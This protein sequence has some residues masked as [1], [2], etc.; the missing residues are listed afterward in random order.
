YN[1]GVGYIGSGKLLEATFEY[2]KAVE[3]SEG[4]PET[5][6]AL[7]HAYAVI[8]KNAQAEKILGDLE[9][10]AKSVYVSPYTLATIYASLDEKDRA[11]D[12]LEEA[13]NEK[14]LDISWH[15]KADLRVDNLRSDPRFHD[16]MRR[17]GL[18]E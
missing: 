18:K 10:K 9:Q 14:S 17:I 16:L 6:A 15:L 5:L 1:L 13:Y 2:Q 4:N 12:L 8:G 11:F 3:L 7:A